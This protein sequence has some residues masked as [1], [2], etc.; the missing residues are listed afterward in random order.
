MLVRTREHLLVYDAARRW[1]MP[2]A[3]LAETT[4]EDGV[5]RVPASPRRRFLV[6]GGD[7]SA[8]DVVNGLMQVPQATRPRRITWALRQRAPRQGAR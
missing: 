2:V 5:W 8:H 4:V 7:G 6:A 3:A 1:V